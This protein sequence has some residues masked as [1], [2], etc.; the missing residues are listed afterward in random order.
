[1]TIDTH[2][3]QSM[4]NNSVTLWMG[5]SM[6]D[7]TT[8]RSTKAA[9]GTDADDIE[10]AVE[11][12]NTVTNSPNPNVMSDICAMN[13]DAVDMKS[14]VPSILMLQPIGRTNRVTR[15]SICSLSFMQRNVIGSA[16]A[17]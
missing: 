9:L 11:V 1:M 6:A 13:I 10:A 3:N 17:L 4:A 12:S 8:R 5:A 15:G 16:A 7:R 2:T 14:A